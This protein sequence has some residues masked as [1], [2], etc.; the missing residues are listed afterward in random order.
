MN[1][2]FK[3][4]LLEARREF[5]EVVAAR[6]TVTDHLELRTAVDSFLIAYDQAAT[7]VAENPRSCVCCTTRSGFECECILED[8]LRETD[9]QRAIREA[10]EYWAAEAA[11]IEEAG[12]CP[13]CGSLMGFTCLCHRFEMCERCRGTGH[14][15]IY[16]DICSCPDCD[17][18]GEIEV[19]DEEAWNQDEECDRCGGSGE[20]DAEIYDP[21]DCPDCLGTGDRF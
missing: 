1:Q 2:D 10:E 20:I 16:G 21:R 14:T 19:E 18:D 5:V 6:Y 9:E 3:D 7:R 8:E 4:Y 12:G 11:A 15:L 13:Q 17:G